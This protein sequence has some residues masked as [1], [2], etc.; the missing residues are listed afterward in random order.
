MMPF[1]APTKKNRMKSY[2]CSMCVHN[3]LGH[4][5]EDDTLLTFIMSYQSSVIAL[6]AWGDDKLN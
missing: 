1:M 6:V 5:D 4:F 2:F 3:L